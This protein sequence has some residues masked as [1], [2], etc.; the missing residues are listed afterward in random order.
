MHSVLRVN[1][2]NDQA[3]ELHLLNQACSSSPQVYSILKPF[4][5]EKKVTCAQHPTAN[6]QDEGLAMPFLDSHHLKPPFPKVYRYTHLIPLT[7]PLLT[8]IKSV[9]VDS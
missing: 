3:P 6:A 2:Y 8:P 9:H 7:G 4:R 5:T 1:T